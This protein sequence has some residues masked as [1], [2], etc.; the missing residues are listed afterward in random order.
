MYIL[1]YMLI[2]LYVCVYILCVCVYTCLYVYIFGCPCI[3]ILECMHIFGY[4]VYIWTYIYIFKRTQDDVDASIILGS[5]PEIEKLV[6]GESKAFEFL[7]T[8]AEL[9][10]WLISVVGGKPECDGKGPLHH[11]HYPS[12]KVRPLR[13]LAELQGCSSPPCLCV[14]KAEAGGVQPPR[15]SRTGAIS[16][17]KQ[18]TPNGVDPT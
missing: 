14:S 11:L 2:Y 17:H 12:S 5:T 4:S 3:R 8:S 16:A 10:L 13:G 18:N 9:T 7:N 15:C 1:V 6:Q